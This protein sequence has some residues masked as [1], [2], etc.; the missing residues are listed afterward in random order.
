MP[1]EPDNLAS[2]DVDVGRVLYVVLGLLFILGA[3][4]A[5]SLGLYAWKA[6]SRTFVSPSVFPQPSVLE[7]PKQEQRQPWITGPH[8]FDTDSEA[9][10]VI[11]IEQAMDMIAK[12]GADGYAPIEQSP[13][14][15]KAPPPA[16]PRA[17]IRN[18]K[19][20]HKG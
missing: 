7:T 15:A 2:P 8:P 9:R 14:A 11:P 4:V 3:G 6:P 13:P 16:R 12:R 10:S 17:P 5:I 18:R 19:I 20:L 1:D